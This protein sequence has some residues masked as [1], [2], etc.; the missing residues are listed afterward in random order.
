MLAYR[1]GNINITALSVSK[2]LFYVIFT[3]RNNEIY[4][5]VFNW[6]RH[7]MFFFPTSAYFVNANT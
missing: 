2:A 5:K 3:K 1:D 6:V 4:N 7:L